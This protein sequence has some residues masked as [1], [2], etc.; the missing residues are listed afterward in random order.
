MNP[1]PE[2]I[3]RLPKWS[4]EHIRDLEHQR[5]SAIDALKRFQDSDE[6]TMISYVQMQHFDG[7]C[8]FFTR[9][10]DTDRMQFTYKGVTLVV[11][12]PDDGGRGIELSWGSEG[13]NGLGDMCFTPTAYQQARIT[14]LAYM[15]R[16]YESLMKRKKRED[17]KKTT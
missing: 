9:H 13:G 7:E 15:P 4:Q 17:E 16:E 5:R 2:Q 6:P 8:Q 12:L 3:E 11:M 14:N 1:T 10:V